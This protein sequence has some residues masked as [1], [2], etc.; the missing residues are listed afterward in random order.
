MSSYLK[1]QIPLFAYKKRR[2]LKKTA[3][4]RGHIQADRCGDRGQKNAYLC[5]AKIEVDSFGMSDVKDTI[6]LRRK[7]SSNLKEFVNGKER[8]QHT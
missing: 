1:K 4:D 8:N 3:A 2:G 6:G 5:I 7:T